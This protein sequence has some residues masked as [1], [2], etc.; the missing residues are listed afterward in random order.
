MKLVFWFAGMHLLLGVILLVIEATHGIN[1]QDASFAVAILF[2]GLNFPTIWALRS[3]SE[4]PS[5]GGVLMAGMVQWVALGVVVTA[6]YRAIAR[7]MRPPV[8]PLATANKH[9]Q[10]GDRP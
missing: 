6:S 3:W 2:S 7:A 10:E 4:A 1:D 5:I 8:K 9:E